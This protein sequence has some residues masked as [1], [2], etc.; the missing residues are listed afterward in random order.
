VR[1]SF[2]Y[3]LLAFALALVWCS[4]ASAAPAANSNPKEKEHD[5]KQI[6]S[7]SF[8]VFQNGHRVGT[9]TFSIYQTSYGSVIQSEFKTENTATQAV[10]TSEMQLNSKGE[11]R[12]YEWKELSPG[13]AQSLVVPN[14][15]FLNQKWT[16]AAGEKEHEQ[17]YL[18]PTS[19][20]ILDDYFFVDRE[21]LAWRFLGMVCKQDKGQMQCLPKQHTQFGILNPHQQASAQISAE[22]LGREKINLKNGPQD[23]LKVEFKNDAGTWQL[24]LDDQFKVQRLAVVGDNTEVDRD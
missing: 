8:G 16:A 7:G 21:L 22:F 5:G 20:A 13:T 2:S 15:D 14:D 18:L 17:P 3:R 12:R 11:I 10:Q 19:T 9:E 24:W 1:L 23:L 4:A 6:D